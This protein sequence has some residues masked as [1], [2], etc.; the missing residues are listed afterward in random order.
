MSDVVNCHVQISKFLMKP[1]SHRTDDGRK[2]YYLDFNDGKIHEEKISILGTEE[3]YYYTETEEYLAKEIESKAGEVFS[4]L[5]KIANNREPFELN[6]E[7]AEIIKN[8]FV[9]A[10]LRS[11]GVK[12]E[13]VSRSVFLKVF[14]EKDQT[15]LIINHPNHVKKLFSDYFPNIIINESDIN[16]VIPH[17]CLYS[18]ESNNT[19]HGWCLPIAPNCCATLFPNSDKEKYMQNGKLNGSVINNAEVAKSFNNRTLSAENT[20]SKKFIIGDDTN[21]LDRLSIVLDDIIIK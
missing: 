20:Y 10:F 13:T 7:E 19:F 5:R 17:C 2:A 11:D 9:Y 16:F 6:G 21:E 1:F 14:S 4:K 15:E 12:R 3:N 8:M 18:I